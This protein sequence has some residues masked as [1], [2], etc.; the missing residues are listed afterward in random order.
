[1]NNSGDQLWMGEQH[2][3]KSMR[4]KTPRNN[5]TE[6]YGMFD[7]INQQQYFSHGNEQRMQKSNSFHYD[8]NGTTNQEVMT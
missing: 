4:H 1:M 5:H 8:N 2:T 7:S 6:N 3:E